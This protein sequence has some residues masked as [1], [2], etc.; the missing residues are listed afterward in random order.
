M[1]EP[2][3][4]EMDVAVTRCLQQLGGA[5]SA[6]LTPCLAE[7]YPN[8]DELEMRQGESITR[9]RGRGYITLEADGRIQLTESGRD[10]AFSG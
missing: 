5:T 6:Q 9:L 3:I 10:L 8:W 4:T 2:E 1:A 7:I